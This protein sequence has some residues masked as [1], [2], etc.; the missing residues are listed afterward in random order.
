MCFAWATFVLWAHWYRTHLACEE[1]LDVVRLRHGTVLEA[2]EVRPGALELEVEVEGARERALCYPDLTGPASRGDLVLLNTTA[3]RLG[4]GTGGYHFV[5]CV[6]GQEPEDG[7]GPGHLVKARYTPLQVQCLCVEEEDSPHRRAVERFE[8]L[9]GMPVVVAELHSQMAAAAAA[10]WRLTEGEAK[11]AYVMTDGG[12]LPFAFSEVAHLLKER[13][14]LASAIT[15]G[16]AF[17]GDLEAVNV[18]SALAAAREVVRA[19]LCVVAMGP[20][21][22]GTGTRLGFSGIEQGCNVDAVNALG[23]RPV[24]VARLS[25]V[26]PR[27]RHRGVSHHTLTALGVAAQTGALLA[28]PVM[29]EPKLEAALSA[30]RGARGM[31]KHAVVVEDGSAAIEGLRA[32]GIELTTMGRGPDEDPEAFLAAGA[33]ARAA[34]RMLEE[35]MAGRGRCDG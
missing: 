30:V 35:G 9:G 13:G 6:Y 12:A 5:V 31:D 4:L 14:V 10:V 11:L 21:V 17:G 32:L 33:A 28:L 2:K 27:G 18:Y 24:A 23:G 19:D 29:E 22:A 34:V 16:Q 8:D 1:G 3:V 7:L 20:G 15:A 26:D 25:F